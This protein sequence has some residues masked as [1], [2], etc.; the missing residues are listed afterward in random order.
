MLKNWLPA[1]VRY[2]KKFYSIRYIS[3]WL[4]G[5]LICRFIYRF[6]RVWI[7]TIKYLDCRVQVSDIF[8]HMVRV[9]K[10]MKLWIVQ[11]PNLTLRKERH[12]LFSIP[13]CVLQLDTKKNCSLNA[14]VTSVVLPYI[15]YTV[16]CA[17]DCNWL[18]GFQY[19]RR[20]KTTV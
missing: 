13:Q 7:N 9:K 8:Q 6:L 15:F 11:L 3:R 1:F 16:H 2:F 4:S 19:V 10:K 12:F 17:N 20:P 18:I 14:C 5:C